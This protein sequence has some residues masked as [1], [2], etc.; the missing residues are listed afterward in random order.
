VSASLLSKLKAP[1]SEVRLPGL[2]RLHRFKASDVGL[3][4]FGWGWG[5]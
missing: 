2:V 1:M 4:T 5:Y 3:G